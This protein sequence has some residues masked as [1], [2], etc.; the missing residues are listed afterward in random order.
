MTFKPE[1]QKAIDHYAAMAPEQRK[2][3]I[4]DMSELRKHLDRCLSAARRAEW[5]H[6]KREPRS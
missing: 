1:V 3:E 6:R 2:R 4:G 5:E